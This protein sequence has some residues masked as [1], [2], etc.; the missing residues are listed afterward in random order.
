[1]ISCQINDWCVGNAPYA[2]LAANNIKTG[3]T[4]AIKSF[5]SFAQGEVCPFIIIIPDKD[6]LFDPV[7]IIRDNEKKS[8][9]K[10]NGKIK[11]SSDEEPIELGLQVT[12]FQ[13]TLWR[14]DYHNEYSD[15]EIRGLP[16]YADREVIYFCL[17]ENYFA[18]FS[19]V[20][21]VSVS[22]FIDE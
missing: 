7:K 3:I 19:N 5:S 16:A 15:V 20:D 4:T 11:V 14:I 21:K 13:R 9:N 12:I 6:K 1:M 2:L 22:E 8:D 17:L 10:S 18:Q